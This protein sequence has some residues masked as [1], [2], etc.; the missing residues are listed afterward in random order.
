MQWPY[1]SADVGKLIVMATWRKKDNARYSVFTGASS[2]PIEYWFLH[3]PKLKNEK[4]LN[5]NSV[6]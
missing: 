2:F 1:N 4:I 3:L 6:T 5:I